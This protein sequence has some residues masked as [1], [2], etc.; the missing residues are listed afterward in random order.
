MSEHPQDL[1][2]TT[3]QTLYIYLGVAGLVGIGFGLGLH[4]FYG[5]LHSTFHLGHDVQV[6]GPTA[7]EHRAAWRQKQA[8]KVA[9]DPLM[10]AS[11]I[12]AD[13]SSPRGRRGLMS[14]TIHEE[15]DS[16]Y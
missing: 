16:D 5:F 8:A 11:P 9:L 7:K 4:F 1:L 13:D 2:L 6:R 12:R 15:I 10:T 3:L 14:Q